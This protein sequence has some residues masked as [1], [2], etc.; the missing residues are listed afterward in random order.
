MVK[1]RDRMLILHEYF[2]KYRKTTSTT[3]T[4]LEQAMTSASEALTTAVVQVL[5]DS[6]VNSEISIQVSGASNALVRALRDAAPTIIEQARSSASEALKTLIAQAVQDAAA[7]L[8]QPSSPTFEVL[9]TL[10][11]QAAQDARVMS[12]PTNMLD[13]PSPGSAKQK[14]PN[15]AE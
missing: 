11:A 1:M 9:K 13:D 15:I 4:A 3:P 2:M 5:Q 7:I 6:R 14:R 8:D 12:A 10:I